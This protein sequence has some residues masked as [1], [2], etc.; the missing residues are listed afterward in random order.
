MFQN[1]QR[2][3]KALAP[4]G[5]TCDGSP[6]WSSTGPD[7]FEYLDD[8]LTPNGIRRIRIDGETIKLL[9]RGEELATS[10]QGVPD[11][12]L[13]GVPPAPPVVLQVHAGNGACAEAIFD[14]DR[15]AAPRTFKA[16]N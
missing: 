15:R 2:I 11:T 9:A 12:L 1:G 3:L 13:L 7:A 8:G 6:C 4:A 5:G 14:T 16:I 10:A